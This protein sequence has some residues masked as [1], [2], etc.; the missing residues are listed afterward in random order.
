MAVYVC[1]CGCTNTRRCAMSS[2]AREEGFGSISSGLRKGSSYG[3]GKWEEST[4]VELYGACSARQSHEALLTV[5][6]KV[7]KKESGLLAFFFLVFHIS[8]GRGEGEWGGRG[9]ILFILTFRFCVLRV[10]ILIFQV[11]KRRSRGLRA[12]RETDRR[13][14]DS[15]CTEGGQRDKAKQRRHFQKW[16]TRF[17]LSARKFPRTVAMNRD[18]AASSSGASSLARAEIYD[19]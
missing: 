7:A 14:L 4:V 18:E 17:R 3:T 13:R 11:S 15:D 1:S 19:T 6:S 12:K 5:T 10:C 16:R 2:L 8:R 9:R